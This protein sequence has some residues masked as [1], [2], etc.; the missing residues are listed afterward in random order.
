MCIASKDEATTTHAGAHISIARNRI[1]GSRANRSGPRR[2]DT[3]A[4][5]A[6][7]HELE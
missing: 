1:D 2:Y 5:A 4:S 3:G 7:C 6:R